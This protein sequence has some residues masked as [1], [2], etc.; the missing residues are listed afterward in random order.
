MVNIIIILGILIA[1]F[2][3]TKVAEL[4]H[5]FFVASILVL[6][7]LFYV[8]FSLV[9]KDAGVDV[10]TA[11]GIVKATGI[12]FNWLGTLFGNMRSITSNAVKLDWSANSTSPKK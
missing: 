1:I 6:L 3:V 7:L 10:G 4:R 9:A 5:K 8:S 12:Y 11:D 2:V